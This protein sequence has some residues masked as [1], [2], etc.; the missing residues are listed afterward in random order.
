MQHTGQFT[1]SASEVCA[2][3]VRSQ[4]S[5]FSLVLAGLFLLCVLSVMIEFKEI[6]GARKEPH[7]GIENVVGP[8][9]SGWIVKDIIIPDRDV[10]IRSEN[11]P[12]YGF[13][14]ISKPFVGEFEFVDRLAGADDPRYKQCSGFINSLHL[15][16]G[17][18][19]E[20]KPGG[21]L[22]HNSRRSSMAGQIEG[23][24]RNYAF[25]TNPCEPNI[26]DE[27]VGPLQI[28]EGCYSHLGRSFGCQ[29]S[30]RGRLDTL[31]AVSDRSRSRLPEQGG[32]KPQ[33]SGRYEQQARKP[34]H[35]PI[36]T[37]VPLALVF[38][39]GS[40]PVDPWAI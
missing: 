38:G 9:N 4:P 25:P 33:T 39:L 19:H 24:V 7:L 13:V 12:L 8:I 3:S 27:H 18:L 23:Y 20:T 29:G 32:E 35:P 31:L 17:S 2:V 14:G 26:T 36:W 22:A 1:T 34:G 16:I 30:L 40:S 6:L 28:S 5:L 37:R 15:L 21:E 11:G 10:N